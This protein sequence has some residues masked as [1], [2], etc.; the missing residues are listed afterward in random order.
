MAL[1]PRCPRTSDDGGNDDYREAEM[2]LTV[3]VLFGWERWC[4]C[5]LMLEARGYDPDDQ[6]SQNNDST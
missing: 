6:I 3:A 5:T 1:T 2:N 4:C